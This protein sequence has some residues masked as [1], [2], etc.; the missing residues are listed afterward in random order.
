MPDTPT[1]P[2]YY[3]IKS[4]LWQSA[5]KQA[6]EYETYLAESP[7]EK[8]DRWHELMGRMPALSDDDA[9]RLDSHG[10]KINVLVMSGVWCGD[11]VRQGP[12]FKQI[13]DVVG[14]HMDLRWVDRDVNEKLR[15]ELHILGAM[16]VPVVLFLTEDYWEV[17]RF[18]D[19]LLG[20]YRRKAETEIGAA[21]AVP[22][23]ATPEDQLLAERAE[24][25]DVFE[26]MIL[27][28]RLSPPLR[29]RHGD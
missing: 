12:M 17:G 18:G 2:K 3:D 22:Y 5:F 15:D 24:W 25:I 16:R 28:T 23:A 27:M 6:H 8:A 1:P 10:R 11:C 20:V 14:E 21:C 7:Q 9:A 29:K 4:D 26:R 19:R 13:A